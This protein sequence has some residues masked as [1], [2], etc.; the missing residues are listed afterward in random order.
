VIGVFNYCDFPV[1]ARNRILDAKYALEV[2]LFFHHPP[3]ARRQR[4][5]GL[6]LDT[7]ALLMPLF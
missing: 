1:P 4:F 5:N 2:N 6:L 7:F 3:V